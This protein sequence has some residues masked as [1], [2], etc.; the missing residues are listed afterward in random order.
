M[1]HLIDGDFASNNGGWGWCAGTGVDPQQHFLVFN[2]TKQSLQFDPSGE[3][4]R[5][6]MEELGEQRRK[7][8]YTH[9]SKCLVKKGLSRWGM[10]RPRSSTRF[11]GRGFCR[12]IKGC[13]RE[14][15]EEEGGVGS[16]RWQRCSCRE[17]IM[18]PCFVFVL[19]LLFSFSCF[20]TPLHKR[21]GG[22][23]GKKRG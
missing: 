20:F 2:P 6:W 22:G 8:L 23:G 16:L 3:Y 13:R 19:F 1:E 18:C 5:T 10:L 21:Q 15:E 4:I 17:V 12:F 9:L 11:P 7:G 14:E